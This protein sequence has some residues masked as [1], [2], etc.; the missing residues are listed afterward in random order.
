MGSEMCIRDR[1]MP[2][3]MEAIGSV[4]YTNFKGEC[5]DDVSYNETL[6]RVWTVMYNYQVRMEAVKYGN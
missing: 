2:V 3:L 4:D 1:V 6:V 5:E